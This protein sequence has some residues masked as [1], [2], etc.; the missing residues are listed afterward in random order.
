MHL[1]M[2]AL[3]VSGQVVDTLRIKELADN[4]AG[5]QHTNCGSILAHG[6]VIVVLGIEGV[7][8]P[9]LYLRNHA[10]ICLC[11]IGA[12]REPLSMCHDP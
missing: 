2:K 4:V 9:S 8:I 1:V 3:Q 7:T 5:L 12:C 11:V 6:P 10:C